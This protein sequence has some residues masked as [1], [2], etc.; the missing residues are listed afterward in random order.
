MRR[1]APLAEEGHRAAERF[2]ETHAEDLQ[3]SLGTTSDLGGFVRIE[4]AGFG[5]PVWNIQGHDFLNLGRAAV[6]ERGSL[7]LRVVVTS[8][9][10]RPGSGLTGTARA[11]DGMIFV[12]L[13]DAP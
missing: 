6:F 10:R 1:D 8:G 7:R 12:H 11:Q 9:S 13:R 5:H 4:G 3:R 2:T